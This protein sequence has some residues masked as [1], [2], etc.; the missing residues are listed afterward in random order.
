LQNNP[1]Q[2]HPKTRFGG[3]LVVKAGERL[4]GERL[5]EL[6]ME[7]QFI[8]KMYAIKERMSRLQYFFEQWSELAEK[9]AK[10]EDNGYADMFLQSLDGLYRSACHAF[11]YMEKKA[12]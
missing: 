7:E 9:D 3:L 2:K 11:E 12:R 6:K 5:E 10:Y 1:L 4:P 8:G